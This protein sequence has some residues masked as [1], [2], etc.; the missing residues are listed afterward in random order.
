MGGYLNT[1]HNKTCPGGRAVCHACLCCV[2][3][4]GFRVKGVGFSGEA[5]SSS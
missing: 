3:Q 1:V 2:A 5:C 4:S